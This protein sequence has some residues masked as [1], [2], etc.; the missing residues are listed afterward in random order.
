MKLKMSRNSVFAVLLRSPWW[1]SAGVAVL[2]CGGAVAALPKDMVWFGVFGAVPFAVISIIAAYRQLTRPSEARVQAVAEATSAM[3]WAEFAG[4]VEAGFKSDGCEVQRL[5]LPGIDFS[6]T[7][8][9]NVALVSAKRW[10]AARIGVEPLRELQAARGQRGAREAIF[11]AL[12]QV[13]DNAW[14]YAKAQGMS[15]MG[16]AELAKLLRRQK[17]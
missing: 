9:G 12:G 7:K 6:L 1:M 2:L 15:V 5:N 11:I 14:Q 17:L 3:S 8:D 10:K 16:A 4:T 13:S